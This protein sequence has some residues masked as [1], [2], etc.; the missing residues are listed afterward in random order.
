MICMYHSVQLFL[1]KKFVQNLTKSFI[2]RIVKKW[3]QY[4]TI[5]LCTNKNTFHI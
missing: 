3:D 4:K 2:F 5:D 1:K